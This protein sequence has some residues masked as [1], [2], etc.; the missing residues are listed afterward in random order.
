MSL[1]PEDSSELPPQ[2][3]FEH[4]LGSFVVAEDVWTSTIKEGNHSIEL[5][6]LGTASAPHPC[7]IAAATKL[8]GFFSGVKEAALLFLTSQEES[9]PRED[10][11]CQGIEFLREDY[12]NHFSLT[13][14][15][16]VDL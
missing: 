16:F 13:F 15:L 5:S 6:V 8:L 11:V 4:T 14:I 9:P 3:T 12:P 7:L 10:F 2:L 1:P